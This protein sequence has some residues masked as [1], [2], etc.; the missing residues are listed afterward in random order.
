MANKLPVQDL[1]VHT[2]SPSSNLWADRT[3]Q[4]H[5]LSVLPAAGEP[6][7]P[8]TN[9]QFE[10]EGLELP[11]KDLYLHRGF[12]SFNLHWAGDCPVLSLVCER[13]WLGI[14]NEILALLLTVP[15]RSATNS[16]LPS[17]ERHHQLRVLLSDDSREQIEIREQA[18]QEEVLYFDLVEHCFEPRD[19]ATVLS[20]HNGYLMSAHR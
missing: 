6:G 12:V 20:V 14:N 19:G 8:Q 7:C 1:R 2:V 4:V 15:V 13:W 11:W 16:V 18:S 5:Q 3:I 17:R 10:G 9:L